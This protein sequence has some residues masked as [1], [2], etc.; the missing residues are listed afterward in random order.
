MRALT[1]PKLKPFTAKPFDT[2]EGPGYWYVTAEG[3]RPLKITSWV[4]ILLQQLEAHRNMPDLMEALRQQSI[5]VTEQDVLE[6]VKKLEGLGLFEGTDAPEA[7]SVMWVKVRLLSGRPLQ[8]F[9]HPLGGLFHPA[10][11]TLIGG[12]GIVS[13]VLF[14]RYLLTP[15][16]LTWGNGSLL[17]FALY[18]LT[19]IFHEIGHVTAATRYGITVPELGVGLYVL[20]PVL[21]ADLTAAWEL[22]R[23]QRVVINLG[24]VYFQMIIGMIMMAIYIA[25][26]SPSLNLAIQL[27]AFALLYNLNPSLRF[28]GF[29]IMSDLMGLA[30]IHDRTRKTVKALF[31]RLIGRPYELEYEWRALKPWVRNVYIT[32][33][34]IYATAF[35][36]AIAGML[37]FLLTWGIGLRK[38]GWGDSSMFIALFAALAVQFIAGLFRRR[39]PKPSTAK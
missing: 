8:R 1:L 26:P 31:L 19:L 7:P 16:P 33:V 32:Y 35:T 21:Y 13:T 38:V 30:N 23:W 11:M 12:V 24:G 20:K 15:V 36:I 17:G 10:V 22:N 9:L 2:A 27:T 37:W 18:L 14:T 25:M 39:K 6:T 3:T 34:A 5:T 28:D 4:L 29:W